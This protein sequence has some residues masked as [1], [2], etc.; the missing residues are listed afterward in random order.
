MHFSTSL[1]LLPLVAAHANHRRH[2]ARDVLKPLLVR[3]GAPIDNGTLASISA[4]DASV[5]P[6]VTSTGSS[7]SST[8]SSVTSTSLTSSTTSSLTSSTTSSSTASS[9]TSSSTTSSTTSSSTT[10]SDTSSVA[11]SSTNAPSSAADLPS[12]L[13]S[14]V[15][16]SAEPTIIRVSNTK[17]ITSTSK[18]T[19]SASA[20][21]VKADSDSDKSSSGLSKPALIGIIVAAAIVGL[22]AAGWTAFR[23]WKLKP[24]NR[25][26]SKMRPI[27]FSPHNDALGTDDFFE[28]TL[29]RTA[30]HSSADR[31]RQQFVS[32]L[33]QPHLVDGVPEHDFTA[34]AVNGA[35][36]GAAYDAYE[37]DPYAHAEQYDYDAA[38]QHQPPQHEYAYDA[39]HGYEYPTQDQA[40]AV[41][42]AGYA[43]LQRGPS[44]GSGS[45]HGHEMATAQMS[46]PEPHVPGR[47][48]GL[49]RPTGGS[50]GP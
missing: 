12:T 15:T 46:F 20:S 33:D 11:P 49:G 50:D 37:Q 1:L 26:D 32:E 28:K 14:S 9:T 30:S 4:F 39:H 10:S 31:Q 45:G 35:G 42:N 21:A 5:S 38:Y 2:H 17:T 24:S 36:H 25:F 43:D 29:Q 44:V 41:D 3:A 16:S 6:S 13:P 19:A 23:K 7:T 18:T 27:D 48:Y 40:T 47:S 34:G 22:F 8:T